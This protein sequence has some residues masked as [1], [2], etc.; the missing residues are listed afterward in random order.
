MTPVDAAAE[1][2]RDQVIAVR[3]TA[4]P[5]GLRFSVRVTL[6]RSG[7][8]RFLRKQ[9]YMHL[10]SRDR[11]EKKFTLTSLPIKFDTSAPL[12]AQFPASHR[13]PLLSF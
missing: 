11:E 7:Y 10:L 6:F 3:V 4:F 2:S 8:K 13:Y 9:E 1:R 12:L 5:F